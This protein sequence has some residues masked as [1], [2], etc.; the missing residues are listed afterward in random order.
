M[1]GASTF[2]SIGLMGLAAGLIAGCSRPPLDPRTQDRLVEVASIG[3]AHAASRSV[4]GVVRARVQSDLGFRVAGKVIERLVDPGQ[5][6]RRGQPLMRIDRTDY[7]LALDAARARS[8]QASADEARYRDLVAAG[9]ISASTY[10]Q[11]RSAAQTAR[12]QM[13]VAENE[14]HYGTLFA[15]ADGIVVETLAEPGQVVSAGQV[16]VRLAH[17]GPREA[18]VSLPETIRPPIGSTAHAT[19]F[20]GPDQDGGR[21]RLRQLS[22]S[23]D[24]QTRTYDARFVLEGKAAKA[25]LGSTVT[26]RL[27]DDHA[28]SAMEV[29]LA[30]IIDRGQGPGVWVVGPRQ[31]ILSWR[32]VRLARVS[33]ESATIAAG[34]QPGEQFVALGA[35]LLHAGQRVRVASSVKVAAR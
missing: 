33:D 35:H 27:P 23:A 10:D 18:E 15:D 26:L 19:L 29:P 6:V 21:A 1:R 32:P 34:L 14:A 16:V 12:A 9:A 3:S 11:M 7:A 4:T 8:A 17:A 2:A 25:P 20:G 5:A 30:A 28:G 24:P 31:P 13:K 22:A